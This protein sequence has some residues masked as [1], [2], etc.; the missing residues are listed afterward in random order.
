MNWHNHDPVR[1]LLCAFHT[2]P[3]PTH[4]S[5]IRHLSHPW[6]RLREISP[7]SWCCHWSRAQAPPLPAINQVDW[8][9]WEGLKGGLRW[10]Q[11]RLRL[12]T[13]RNVCKV[14][15]YVTH[16][17]RY[18]SVRRVTSMHSNAALSLESARWNPFWVLILQSNATLCQDQHHFRLPLCS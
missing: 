15:M 1:H 16:V 4:L 11:P 5:V 12:N 17:Y 10:V 2:L 6:N 13:Q 9:H 3:G 18:I 8:E 7:N 14:R